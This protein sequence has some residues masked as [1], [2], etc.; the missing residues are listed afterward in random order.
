M[1][2]FTGKADT[3]I[4]RC[5]D[6]PDTPLEKKPTTGNILSGNHVTCTECGASGLV[7]DDGGIYKLIDND[8]RLSISTQ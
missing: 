2:T 5:T 1:L 8:P 4:V 3:F 7:Y 6:H